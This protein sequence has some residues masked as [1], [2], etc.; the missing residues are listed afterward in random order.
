MN[1]AKAITQA[2]KESGIFGTGLQ[3]KSGHYSLECDWTAAVWG[4]ERSRRV[5]S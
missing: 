4:H 2:E 3:A 1:A 5:T